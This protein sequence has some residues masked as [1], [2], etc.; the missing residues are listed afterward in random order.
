MKSL[1]LFVCA[2]ALA[3]SANSHAFDLVGR[4]PMAINRDSVANEKNIRC[5]SEDARVRLMFGKAPVQSVRTEGM[6]P[7]GEWKFTVYDLWYDTES[8]VDFYGMLV[9]NTLLFECFTVTRE[10]KMFPIIGEYNEDTHKLAIK[11]R[12]VARDW[13]GRYVFLVPYVNT[14][15]G[16]RPGDI[17]A[18]YDPETGE[19]KFNENDMITY[20]DYENI[21]GTDNEYDAGYWYQISFAKRSGD[22]RKEDPDNWISLGKATLIDGWLMP[23]FG[24]D[25]SRSENW[26]HP[27]LVQYKYN[28][29]IYRLVNPFDCEPLAQYNTCNYDGYI[30]FDVSDPNHVVFNR[31]DCGWASPETV[32]VRKMYCYN[33]IGYYMEDYKM[34]GRKFGNAGDFL[35]EFN[36]PDIPYTTFKNGVVDFGAML[37]GG[38]LVYDA[39]FGDA[40]YPTGGNVWIGRNMRTRIYFPDVEVTEP[41]I[42]FVQEPEVKVDNGGNSAE[43]SLKFEYKHK[44]DNATIFAIVT[45][46]KTGK[47]VARKYINLKRFTKNEYSFVLDGLEKDKDY[48]YSLV[49]RIEGALSEVLTNSDPIDLNFTTDMRSL[50][51]AGVDGVSCDADQP[52]YLNLQG[53]RIE[54]PSRGEI[55][56][57]IAGGKATKV[58]F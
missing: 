42:C 12:Y 56:I 10:G 44:P 18:E 31:V 57:K 37:Y 35:W 24:Y 53:V 8:E 51:F 13:R 19:L 9:G 5:L 45:D 32:G 50:D 52:V 25:Q 11:K 1:P 46:K 28:D 26:L 30:E 22:L 55:Y 34:A 58:V 38:E 20:M 47:W 23:I 36:D 29:K 48:D 2:A 16:A 14:S 49:I 40:N 7:E 6:S 21:E 15:T 4:H 39:N 17:E 41:E 54:N 3:V 33:F 27:E 43:I